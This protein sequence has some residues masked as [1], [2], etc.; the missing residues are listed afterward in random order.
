[1]ATGGFYEGVAG[2]PDLCEAFVAVTIPE[3]P[4][5]LVELIEWD[6]SAPSS[7]APVFTDADADRLRKWAL[8]ALRN[9]ASAL[10]MV[11]EGSRNNALNS[12]VFPLAGIAWCGLSEDEVYQAMVWACTINKLI[13]DDGI[14]AFNATFKSGWN[15]GIL[16]P[17][18]GPRERYP[19][20]DIVIDL[21]PKATAA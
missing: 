18:S 16:K 7:Q 8:G 21:K 9:K 4:G 20:S 17:L 19:D 13:A 3:I 10:A 15:S 6:D 2:W 14:D 12:A 1:M 11:R 5:W